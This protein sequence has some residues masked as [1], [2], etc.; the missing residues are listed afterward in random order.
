MSTTPVSYELSGTEMILDRSSF[1]KERT[2]WSTR[3]VLKMCTSRDVLSFGFAMSFC[4]FNRAS[5]KSSSVSGKW[6]GSNPTDG[7]GIP[8]S[9]LSVLVRTE[10]LNSSS[11]FTEV[12]VA[13]WTKSCSIS[14]RAFRG[15]FSF[16]V[17]ESISSILLSFFFMR[18]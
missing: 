4:I 15:D 7:L 3:N 16:Y 18:A 13:S 12:R 2:S 14:T 5:S 10:E 1:G 6:F 9:C 17:V 11:E 8:E